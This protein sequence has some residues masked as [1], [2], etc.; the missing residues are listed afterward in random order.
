MIEVAAQACALKIRAGE[1]SRWT[2]NA[3]AD[4]V[5]KYLRF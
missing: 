4:A 3:V 1:L 2:E 5:N